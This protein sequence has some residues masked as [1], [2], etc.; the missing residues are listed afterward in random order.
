MFEEVSPFWEAFRGLLV[1]R[2]EHDDVRIRNAQLFGGDH[3]GFEKFRRRDHISRLAGFEMVCQ[4]KRF[5][6]DVSA[7]KN[8]PG[9]DDSEK[10]DRVVELSL[11]AM[12]NEDKGCANI[13]WRVQTNTIATLESQLSKAGNHLPYHAA[14]LS[15]RYGSR[16][17]Q[18]IEIDLSWYEWKRPLELMSD[19]LQACPD[20][21]VDNQTS[22]IGG[23]CSEYVHVALLGTASLK[24]SQGNRSK[25]IPWLFVERCK[26]WLARSYGLKYLYLSAARTR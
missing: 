2:I 19:E 6:C 23:P 24:A 8:A 1:I 16:G 9:S 22:K 21:T 11:S 10:Y 26:K 5:V 3:H 7:S 14:S 15:R 18:R 13:V 4:L 25:I 12:P 20:H 17:I